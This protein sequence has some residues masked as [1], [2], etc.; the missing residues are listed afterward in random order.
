[1]NGDLGPVCGVLGCHD[2]PVRVVRH[3]DHGERAVCEQHGRGAQAQLIEV[4]A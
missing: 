1:M 3:P 2:E 4:E